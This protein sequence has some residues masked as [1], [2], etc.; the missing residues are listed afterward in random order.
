[1]APFAPHLAEELW[2][3]L[4][5]EYS[6]HTQSWPRYD[7]ELAREEMVELVVMINGKPRQTLTVAVDIEKEQAQ[8][9]AMQSK[10]ARQ[11]L[12]GKPPRRLVFI[13]GRNGADPKVNIV[14]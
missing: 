2:A 10:T 11:F 8:A 13:P 9:I 7:A 1:M 5:Q 14:I 3:R 6:V 12:H 4:G